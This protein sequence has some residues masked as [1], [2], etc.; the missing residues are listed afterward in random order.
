MA[1]VIALVQIGALGV[2]NTSLPP[3]EWLRGKHIQTAAVAYAPYT[4]Y[5]DGEWHGYEIDVLRRAAQLGGFTYS[6][7]ALKK[8]KNETWNDTLMRG[9]KTNNI[10]ATWWTGTGIYRTYFIW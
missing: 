1:A 10:T 4:W 8:R 6:L 9:L 7:N 2:C 3:H 5:A